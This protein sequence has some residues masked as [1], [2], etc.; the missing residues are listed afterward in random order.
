MT[1][2]ET[3]A[4]TESN[5]YKVP[6]SIAVAVREGVEDATEAASTVL[7]AIGKTLTNTVYSGCYYLAFGVTF[8]A[9]TVAKLLPVDTLVGRGLHDGA[10]AAKER[11][12]RQA[13]LIPETRGTSPEYVI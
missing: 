2:T 5:E 6:E 4:N 7:P 13:D 3:I 10:E 8:S 9:L 11:I 1:S 12:S